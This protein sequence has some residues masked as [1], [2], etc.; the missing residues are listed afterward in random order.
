M[1]V[2]TEG[3][4]PFEFVLSVANGHRSFEN[5]L[6]KDGEGVLAAGTVIGV[7]TS[8]NTNEIGRYRAAT[9]GR[10]DGSQTS[11]GV[12]CTNVDASSGDQPC[13]VLVRDAEV[14]AHML[15]WSATLDTP[16]E[17]E[18]ALTSLAS[19]GIIARE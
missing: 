13:V 7:V 14:N 3:A 1:P 17:R 16:A 19:K 4:H 5:A 10:S 2:L 12:L 11:V 9:P 8:G 15:K 18:T 6:I